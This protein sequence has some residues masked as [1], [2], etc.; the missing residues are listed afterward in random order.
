MK[1]NNTRMI[2]AEQ[3]SPPVLAVVGPYYSEISIAVTRLLNLENIPQI[4]YGST[5]GQ[6]SDKM[7]YPSFMRTVPEDDHQVR[8]IISILKSHQWTWIGLVATDSEAGR[9][10]VER[11][12]QHASENGI[13]IAFTKI[14]HEA[15]IDQSLEDDIRDTVKSITEN[16]K[17]TVIVSFAKVHHMMDLFRSLYKDHRGKKK[18]WVAN[19]NWSESA[20]VLGNQT[21]SDVGTIFGIMLKS[22][23]TTKYKQYL[24]NLD[25][26]PD[27][28]KNN[29]FLYDYLNS[30]GNQEKPNDTANEELM[31]NIYPSVSNVELAVRAIAQAVSNLCG[32]RDCRTTQ[33]LQP[34][35]VQEALK[36]V[37]FGMDG[38]RYEFNKRGDLN[39]GYDVILWKQTPTLLNVHYIVAQYCIQN[40]NL[41]FISTNTLQ[42]FE[43][44]TRGVISRC[45]KS[46]SPGYRKHSAQSQ[47]VCCFQCQKCPLHYFSNASDSTKCYPCN[48]TTHYSAEE[49]DKCLPRETDYMKWDDIYHI[50]LLAF[51]FLGGLLTIIVGIIFL[52]CWNT[53]VVRASVGPICILLLF[54]LLSTFASVALFGGEPKLWKCKAGH[55]LFSLS[56]TLCVSCIMV[57]SLKIIMAFEFDPRIQ[58]LLKK[59]YKPYM[60][61]AVCFLGQVFICAM[62]LAFCPPTI[63]KMKMINRKNLL[64]RCRETSFTTLGA[65]FS[66]IGVLALICFGLAFKGRKLPQSYN[67]AK[68][69]TFSMLIYFI[70]WI[71]FG[72]V[73]ANVTNKYHSAVEMGV[74]LISAYGIL[75]CQFITKCYIILFRQKANT[76]SAFRRDIRNF[77]MSSTTDE[78]DGGFVSSLSLGGMQNPA[79]DVAAPAS[80][81]QRDQSWQISH[82]D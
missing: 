9:Y 49:G 27:H 53:P 24:K 63:E 60:I 23:N 77:T 41:T 58:G 30:T 1:L 35:E 59:L 38:A 81:P 71:I 2:G 21:L 17:V 69:I 22:G 11:L 34:I 74:I 3:T 15:L 46:C 39:T 52:V 32:S 65:M 14:L 4:S 61:I 72:P 18:V 16:P 80:N 29:T 7:R 64:L 19:D 66:Y 45:S 10:A 54:S 13:C 82:P 79:F 75:S 8:A 78:Q 37:K 5:S 20:K 43:K 47:P 55:V 76:V 31:T 67:D 25:V 51:T 44:V 36:E 50:I 28:Q 70:C 6:L 56:F 57:K 68:F 33:R 48:T 40:Q 26:N 42:D 73:Y 12:Q 62:L